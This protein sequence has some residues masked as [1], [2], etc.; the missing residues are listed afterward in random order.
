MSSLLFF[1]VTNGYKNT[2]K[3]TGSDTK[4]KVT[5]SELEQSKS[6]QKGDLSERRFQTKANFIVALKH[7]NRQNKWQ[8]NV[9]KSFGMRRPH[10]VAS[11]G[12]SSFFITSLDSGINE[13]GLVSKIQKNIFP[14]LIIKKEFLKIRFHASTSSIE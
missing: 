6:F 1:L 7:L 2:F 13:G 10:I 3:S 9:L 12:I 5:A 8:H 14:E 11:H 4:V